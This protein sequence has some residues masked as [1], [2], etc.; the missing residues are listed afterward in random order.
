MVD[1]FHAGRRLD[2]TNPDENL[3][4]QNLLERDSIPTI[5][6]AV[7]EVNPG[8]VTDREPRMVNETCNLVFLYFSVHHR[9]NLWSKVNIALFNLD[10]KV[11]VKCYAV[12]SCRGTFGCRIFRAKFCWRRSRCARKVGTLPT[13]RCER[14]PTT[15]AVSWKTSWS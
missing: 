8:S 4:S 12:G 9:S 3:F 11:A 5:D 15:K 7:E 13:G 10:F 1:A 14:C 2:L 6:V